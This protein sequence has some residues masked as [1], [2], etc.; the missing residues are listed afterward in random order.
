[1]TAQ[2]PLSL[3][4]RPRMRLEDFVAGPN[5]AVLAACA[6]L[7]TGRH[8]QLY[9]AGPPRSGRTHLLLGTCDAAE[10]AGLT[11]GYLPMSDYRTAPTAAAQGM[12]GLDLL[13]IDDVDAIAGDPAWEEAL[14]VLYNSCRASHCRL[15]FAAGSAATALPA[16]LPDL[17]SRLAWGLNFQLAPLDDAGR[18]ELLRRE[19]A[20]RG[21]DLP[22]EVGRYLLA[23]CSRETIALL[24]LVDRLDRA[25]LAARRRLTVPF[26]REVL[27]A[28][29]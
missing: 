6:D 19:S 3:G 20:R 29:T 9:L 16:R 22:E 26:V 7:V 12:D 15:V 5:A 1:M 10:R 13:A 23:R 14:F 17:R 21:M 18:L 8:E 4:L 28:G 25:A 2:L 24:D 11:A 27:G